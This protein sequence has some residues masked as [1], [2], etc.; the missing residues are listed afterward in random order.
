MRL[1]DRLTNFQIRRKK[2]NEKENYGS[3]VGPIVVNFA[4]SRCRRM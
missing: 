2:E 4:F 3:A 1:K